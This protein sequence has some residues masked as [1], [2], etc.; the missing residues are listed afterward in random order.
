MVL[1]MPIFAPKG[2]RFRTGAGVLEVRQMRIGRTE[3]RYFFASKGGGK[4]QLPRAHHQ[5]KKNDRD[6][7][8][9]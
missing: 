7:K 4:Q 6:L 3:R 9:I 2:V 5:R 1:S 8:V